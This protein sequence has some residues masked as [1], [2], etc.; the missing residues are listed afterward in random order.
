MAEDSHRTVKNFVRWLERLSCKGRGREKRKPD[1]P[2][3][4]Y[5]DRDVAPFL[6]KPGYV[7]PESPAD[8][9]M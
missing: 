2:F 1:E 8:D 7:L 4:V 3:V 6:R 9:I 5:A